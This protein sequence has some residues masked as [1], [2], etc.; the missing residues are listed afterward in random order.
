MERRSSRKSEKPLM[1]PK[2]SNGLKGTSCRLTQMAREEHQEPTYTTYEMTELSNDQTLGESVQLHDAH[3]SLK[4]LSEILDVY[5]KSTEPIEHHI[6]IA[7]EQDIREDG[8]DLDDHCNNSTAFVLLSEAREAQELCPSTNMEVMRDTSR[9]TDPEASDAPESY[10]ISERRRDRRQQRKMTAKHEDTKTARMIQHLC[11]KTKAIEE[12]TNRFLKYSNASDDSEAEDRCQ[13]QAELAEIKRIRAETRVI[14]EE[15]KLINLEVR[16]LRAKRAHKQRRERHERYKSER[17]LA[18]CCERS[19]QH[20]Y[21]REW[22]H[23]F[24]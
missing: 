23:S 10:V 6:D 24:E 18:Q 5:G 7:T 17:S 13:Q 22:D 15:T 21:Y 20:R 16:L 19:Q 3:S 9:N 12:E 1:Q 2:P 8:E 11:S 4:N 14:E